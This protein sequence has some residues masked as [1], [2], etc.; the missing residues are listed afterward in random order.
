MTVADLQ[1]YLRALAEAVAA[2][3]GSAAKDLA[4]AADRLGPFDKMTVADFAQFLGLALEYR[5]TGKVTLPTGKTPKT[6]TPKPPAKGTGELLGR[7]R[8]L[9]DRALDPSVTREVVEREVKA[10]EKLTKANLEDVA[11]ALEIKKPFKT[12]PDV[13]TALVGYVMGRKGPAVRPD[14]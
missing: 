10:F 6:A 1:K 11:R 12:K 4:D 7:V 14:A 5:T 3:K 8:S 2:G 9:H 13:I